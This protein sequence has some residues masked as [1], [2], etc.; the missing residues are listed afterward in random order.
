VRRILLTGAEGQVGWELRRTLAPLGE[1]IAFNRSTLDLADLDRL[2][3]T[4]REIKPD[5]IVNPAAYTAVDRAEAEESLAFRINAK[6]PRV[7]AE[8]AQR[9]GAWFMHYSTDYVFD[10]RKPGAYVE[11]DEPN[12]LNAYGRTKLAGERAIAAVGGR[13]IV[14]RTS[15][16]YA[17]RGRN[18][19]LTMLRLGQE[20][21]ELKVVADQR[22]A[23]TWARMIAET[24]SAAAVQLLS[25]ARSGTERDVLAGT[26]HLTCAGNASWHD[27]ACAI[28]ERRPGIKAPRVEPIETAQYPTPAVRPLNSVLSNTRLQDRFG[29]ALPDWRAALSLC[30]A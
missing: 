12:P 19:L 16:V 4:V 30:L 23:P 10:G 13:H 1:V 20:R 14:F 26:Y 24:S 7:M 3:T 17:D 29:L 2:R 21:D 27:F 15:W 9:L 6:A 18:F 25:T 28:F 8:E 22:G 11:D 5:L